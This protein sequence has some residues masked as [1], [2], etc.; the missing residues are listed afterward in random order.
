MS[1]FERIRDRLPSLYRPADDDATGEPLPLSVADILEING[2]APGDGVLSAAHGGVLVTL[3]G[4]TTIQRFRLARGS[5]DGSLAAL[6]IYRLSD[7]APLAVPAAVARVARERAVLP[8]HFREQRFLLRLKRPGLLS[9]TLWAM[10][11]ALDE[12]DRDASHVMQSRWLDYADHAQFSPY[13]RRGRVIEELDPLRAGDPEIP[14][15][16][17][18]SDLARMGSMLALLPWREPAAQ[19]ERVEAYRQRIRRIVAMYRDGLG[20]TEAMRRMIEAQ[21]P[22]DLTADRGLQDRPFTLEEFAPVVEAS[23]MAAARGAPADMVGPLMRWK[24]KNVGIEAA[25]PTI[26]IQGVAPVAEKIDATERPEIELFSQAAGEPRIAIAYDG[27]VAP[28][29]TVRIRAAHASWLGGP[30]G[31]RR[32]DSLPTGGLAADPTAA[33]PWSPLDDG[34]AETVTA[35]VLGPDAALWVTTGGD[36]SAVIHRISEG[37]SEVIDPSMPVV[38]CLV[39]DGMSLLAGTMSGVLR[40]PLFPEGGYD[41][42]PPLED[43]PLLRPAVYSICPARGGGWWLGTSTGLVRMDEEGSEEPFVLGSEAGSG[44]E[45]HVVY[46]EEGGTLF[47][48]GE[49][50][51]FCYQPQL[52]HWYWYRGEDRSEQARDWSPYRPG[53]AGAEGAFP[54]SGDVFLPTVRAI[55][56]GPDASLWI[57]TDRGICRYLA[58]SVGGPSYTTLL[59]AFPD[60]ATGAVRA[61][62]VDARGQLWFATDDGLFRYDGRDWWQLQ[63]DALVRLPLGSSSPLDDGTIR[64]WRFNRALDR[65]EFADSTA[66]A[67]G[68]TGFTGVPRGQLEEAVTAIAWTDFAVADLGSWDGTHFTPDPGAVPAPLRSRIKPEETRVV[69]GGFPSIPRLPEGDS[70]WRYLALEPDNAPTPARLPAWTREGRLLPPPIDRQAVLEGRHGAMTMSLSFFDDAAFAFNPSARV[71]MTWR[72]RHPLSVLARLRRN[73]PEEIINPVLLDRVWEGM[74]Q[75]RP[76]GVRTQLAVDEEIVRG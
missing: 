54:A 29:Q 63:G 6:E 1:S 9:R 20:T 68:W 52:D 35:M 66:P 40:L 42:A 45:I 15:F 55:R 64:Q 24:G 57:G 33:G 2:A 13:V 43:P 56:R 48:G 23:A 22:V 62:E 16:P 26:Y 30:S 19:R 21:L 34:P 73:S 69:E 39:R 32:A 17:Y 46:E 58:R 25:A 7:D 5:V 12:W 61:I 70:T 14:L 74:Q 27:T 51:I 8:T 3:P 11:Q 4:A 10:S 28:G 53:S 44:A 41:F 36:G 67:A 49:R 65:W 71:W 59:E 37:V 76:A 72:T 60:L 18:V 38:N 31:L 75:V 47:A 50:G